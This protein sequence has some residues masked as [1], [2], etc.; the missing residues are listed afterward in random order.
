MPPDWR[1]ETMSMPNIDLQTTELIIVAAVALTMLLQVIVLLAL[2][3]VARKTV[4]TMHEELADMRAAILGVIDKVEP[5]LD[6]TREILAHT[7]PKI[8]S[9]VAD[10]AVVAQK[11]RVETNDVQAAATE[12]I[13]RFRRQGARIDSMLTKTFDVVDRASSF[14]TET[15]SKP[16]RQLAGVLASAKAV[17]ETLRNGAP[18]AHAHA[19]EDHGDHFREDKDFF[20]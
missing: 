17:V 5:I 18:D 1:C 4:R 19:Q 3:V 12:I 2:F 8:E 9:A 16:M 10:L 7:G 15:I 14:M 13:E 11:L 20:V 6:N